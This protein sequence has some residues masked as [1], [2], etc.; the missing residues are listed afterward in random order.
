MKRIES[1]D[2]RKPLASLRENSVPTSP[3]RRLDI[4]A[5][6]STSF[7][8]KRIA[9]IKGDLAKMISTFECPQKSSFSIVKIQR[10][11]SM[12][13]TTPLDVIV[14]P[15]GDGVI[16]NAVDFPVYG[17][18]DDVIDALEML[19]RDI[20]SLYHDLMEDDNLAS[21]WL[22]VKQF[23]KERIIAPDEKRQV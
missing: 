16:A 11:V 20:E 3:Y 1:T 5:G 12:N 14:E 21:E 6:D 10:L 19:K 23:L 4:S 22:Q 7:I 13:L 9:N 2:T 8:N 17:S 18:G 15:D